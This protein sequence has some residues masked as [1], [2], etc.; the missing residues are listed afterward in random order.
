MQLW[1]DTRT[2]NHWAWMDS[3]CTTVQVGHRDNKLSLS[4]WQCCILGANRSPHLSGRATAFGLFQNEA[5]SLPDANWP[6]RILQIIFSLNLAVYLFSC[7]CASNSFHLKYVKS[8]TF[9]CSFIVQI[10]TWDLKE[11][12][13]KIPFLNCHTRRCQLICHIS[14][15]TILFKVWTMTSASCSCRLWET[16]M[17]FGIT[18]SLPATQ[19]SS[20][21]LSLILSQPNPSCRWVFCCEQVIGISL[22]LS[23]PS[24][25]P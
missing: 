18:G 23:P 21:G 3:Y 17:M 14:Y 7:L 10:L 5:F 13:L 16:A 25:W 15:C 2:L 22:Y 8:L 6:G 24:L 1:T 11:R 20:I 9:L 12:E 4:A 19:K